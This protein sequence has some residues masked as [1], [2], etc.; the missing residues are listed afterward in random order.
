MNPEGTSG[1]V[2]ERVVG[3][4]SFIDARDGNA[5][6]RAL[7]ERLGIDVRAESEALEG[8]TAQERVAWALDHFKPR[9][10]LSSSFGAQS[11][12]S[13]H[14]LTSQWPDVPVILVDTGYLFPETYRFI[15]ELAERLSLNLKVYRP[16]VS[17]AWQEARRGK[18]WENGLEGLEEYNRINKVGPMNRALDELG[19][20]AWVTGLRR[21][22]S[23]TRR[24]LPV[25]A[26][27]SGRLKVHPIIDWSNKATH[28][29]LVAHDLP[30][31]PLWHEG[32]L[33][34]GDAHTSHKLTGEMTEEEA[35]FFGL[36]RECG[37]HDNVDFV[38]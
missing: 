32:Y 9:L 33:S 35:R 37:L 22:Q 23:S 15:D 20:D 17:A 16:D 27:G 8:R 19:V 21:E 26:V 38:I 13:L 2:A 5:D 11:A 34:I 14:L 7:E 4:A 28:E 36:K 29:Y 3:D 6:V 10:A 18:L 1:A 25:L 24:N 31:N 12:V 30:Y